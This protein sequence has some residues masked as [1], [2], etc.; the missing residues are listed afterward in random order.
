MQVWLAP[1]I[2]NA[3]SLSRMVKYL[4]NDSGRK[5]SGVNGSFWP[6]A[7]VYE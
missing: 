4:V 3:S 6:K 7:D 1:N 5:R 2:A